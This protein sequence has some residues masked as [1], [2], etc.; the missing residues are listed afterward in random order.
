MEPNPARDG[1]QLQSRTLSHYL[2]TRKVAEL[3]GGMER[4]HSLRREWLVELGSSRLPSTWNALLAALRAAEG[5]TP[6][7]VVLL[8]DRSD[9]VNAVAVRG[10]LPRREVL[11]LQVA[12]RAV[13]AW[14]YGAT[15]GCD[16]AADVL[17]RA[18]SGVVR[19]DEPGSVAV[20]FWHQSNDGTAVDS[21][22]RIHC[23]RFAEIAANY[24]AARASLEPLVAMAAPWEHGRLVFWHGPPGTGKTWALRALIRE[25]SA[26]SPEVI[27]D[28]EPFFASN[29]YLQQVLLADPPSQPSSEGRYVTE[30]ERPR[31][32]VLEDAPQLV[33]QESRG[34][35]GSRIGNLLSMTDGILGQGL[36]AVFLIT[37]NEK[38]ARVDPAIRRPGRCL[39]ELELPKFTAEEAHAWLATKGLGAAAQPQVDGEKS[40][41]ELYELYHRGTHSP[42]PPEERLGFAARER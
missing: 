37:T 10:A 36:R 40:L 7:D 3:V 22:R 14:L 31:L 41:A 33:L 38:L 25:W 26:L 27:T 15:A 19:V 42:R 29:A 13:T 20:R 24:P 17:C 21:L 9:E 39:Q 8:E 32:F 1:I 6:W 30:E 28:P 34:A 5:T 11:R 35:L 2:V 4:L 12:A 18:L 23:P 16:E